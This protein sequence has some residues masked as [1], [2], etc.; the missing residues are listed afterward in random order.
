[1]MAEVCHAYSWTLDYAM[2]MPAS[3]FYVMAREARFIRYRELLDLCDVAPIATGD[4]KYTELIRKIYANGALGIHA[5]NDNPL[6]VPSHI[7]TQANKPVD[8]KRTHASL[9]DLFAA[10]KGIL[11]HGR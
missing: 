4:P 8:T 3:Q 10:K 5:E 7:A 1:M 11:R 2:N 9:C 6:P